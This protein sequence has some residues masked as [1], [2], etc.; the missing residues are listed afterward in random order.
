MR[1]TF[2][3]YGA[4]GY[5]GEVAAERAVQMGLRPILAGRNA[6]ALA[7]IAGTLGVE[8]RV[9]ALD[10]APAVERALT[11]AAVVLHCAGPFMYTSRQMV[12]ACLRTGTHY[13]DITGE[14]PVFEAIAA[15]GEQA[16]SRG[17]MLLPGVGFD[18]VPTD[19]LAVHLKK[20]LPSATHLALAFQGE[21]RA[22]LPPGTQRT[23]I[24]LLPHGNRVRIDG[25]LERQT[26]PM[27]TRVVDFGKGPVTVTQLMWGD[28]FTAYHSTGIPNIEDYTVFPPALQKQL[29]VMQKLRP[30]LKIPALRNLLKRGVKPGATAA[31]RAN[32]VT[33]VWGEV[34]DDAGRTAVS[35]LHG[36]E[37]GVEWTVR[38]A[39][40]AVQRVLAGHVTPGYQTPAKA[41]GAD[42]VLDTAEVTREDL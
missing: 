7:R 21:G 16:K 10:D 36:P 15:R 26:R 1:S 41:F 6:D 23:A 32:A 2:I 19:C 25:R 35:R 3:L 29:A 33:H 40:G 4:T 9:F 34:A 18:V 27:K 12:D 31:Q 30:L 14:L 22:G 42:F 38:T 39:L 37:A 24:E 17:V 11:D 20:R 13:L 8:H 5:V 28:V